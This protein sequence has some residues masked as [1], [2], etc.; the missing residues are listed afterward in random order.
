MNNRSK[1]AG[2]AVVSSLS[3][4][5]NLNSRDHCTLCARRILFQ[6]L[7]ILVFSIEIIIASRC[8]SVVFRKRQ[9]CR[10]KSAI[11]GRLR[12]IPVYF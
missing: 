10:L 4:G 11:N 3:Y 12:V 7:S 1:G 5:A 6:T 8:K 2:P 9:L